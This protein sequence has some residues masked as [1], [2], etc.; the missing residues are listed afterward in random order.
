MDANNKMP[1]SKFLQQFFLA[2]IVCWPAVHAIDASASSPKGFQ[3][4]N[5]VPGTSMI[6]RLAAV[7]KDVLKSLK[8]FEASAHRCKKY[9]VVNTASSKDGDIIA[10]ER[11][12]II[13]GQI[14][15]YWT[16]DACGVRQE[17]VLIIVADG[18][19]GNVVAI[20]DKSQ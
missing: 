3:V 5:E 16:V 19:G 9:T 14:T 4:S 18:K 8:K 11:G 20:S 12:R 2:S 10:D 1:Q 6:R 7:R 17:L 15:D 13:R